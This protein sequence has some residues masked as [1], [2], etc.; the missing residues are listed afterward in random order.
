MAKFNRQRRNLLI[1]SGSTALLSM[2][3]LPAFAQS[4]TAI[5]S[6]VGQKIIFKGKNYICSRS[7]GKL[8][9]SVLA[10]AKP[11]IVVHPAPGA[12]KS[13]AP[14]VTSTPT[15]VSGYLVA[16]ISDL[17]EG[18]SK[19]VTAKDLS[20]KSQIIALFLS[21][22]VVTAHSTICTH[23][24]CQVA[25]AGKQLDCPCHGSVYDAQTGAVI[26]GPAPA[27]LPPYK[28]AQ[29]GGDIYII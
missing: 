23:Q 10:P 8:I 4:P 12:S 27:P 19:I 22:G 26:N 20:G 24:G 9:W 18:Q 17:V 28:V 16:K 2:V 29:V 1:G 13:S 15:K 14:T 5:C 21:N 3:P 6:K 25:A 11:P 7:G